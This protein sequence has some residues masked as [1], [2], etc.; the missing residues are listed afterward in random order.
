MVRNLQRLL[1]VIVI[2]FASSLKGQSVKNVHLGFPE[3]WDGDK[4]KELYCPAKNI[5][6]FIDGYFLC[7]L[8]ASYGN[9]NAPPGQKLTHMIDAIGA[10]GS[11]HISNGQVKFSA[12]YYPSKPY[13]IWEYYDRN[14]SKGSV[15]WAGW[16][17]Y[18]L[19]AMTKW[20]QVPPN[21]DATKFHPNLDFWKIGNKVVAGT[22]APYWVGY[23]FDVATLSDFKQ[24]P[25][26]E[27]NDIFNSSKSKMVPISMA[28]HERVDGTGTIWGSF[29][30]M[31][32]HD[33]IFYQAI[34]TIDSEGRRKVISM[35]DYGVW[36]LNECGK[37]DEYVGDKANLPGYVHSITSTEN[38]IILPISSLLINPCKFKEPPIENNRNGIQK[39]GLWG[40]DFY[41]MVPV[42]FLIFNKKTFKWTTEKP[43]EVF[44]SMFISHQLNAYEAE[45]GILVADM[46][47]YDSHEPYIKY[48]YSS[49]LTNNLY[50][51]TA[52]LLRFT[53][54]IKNYKVKY[55]Y[56]LP[57]ETISGDFPQINHEYES[58]KYQWTYLVEYPFASDNSIIKI[59]VQEPSGRNNLKFSGESSMVLHEPYFIPTPGATTEDD[60]VLLVRGLEL[61]TNKASLL[62]INATS[63]T[64]IGRA[65]VGISIPFGFHNRFFS[66]LDLGMKPSSYYNQH[67]SKI[68]R[69]PQQQNVSSRK[70]VENTSIQTSSIDTI[71]ENT[72]IQNSSV[73]TL[74]T[75]EQPEQVT[76]NSTIMSTTTTTPKSI[77]TTKHTSTT[78]KPTTTTKLIEETSKSSPSSTMMTTIT[79]TNP[80]QTTEPPIIETK[81]AGASSIYELRERFAKYRKMRPY[82][83]FGIKST[84]TPVDYTDMMS[85]STPK[86]PK[87]ETPV[88]Q[89]PIYLTS[90]IP[91]T[92]YIKQ[93]TTDFAPIQTITPPPYIYTT[94]P[95]SSSTFPTK[96]TTTRQ[97]P[98]TTATPPST[99]TVD[100]EKTSSSGKPTTEDKVSIQF[101]EDTLKTLCSW[102]PKVFK[103]I[104]TER[105]LESGHSALKWMAPIKIDQTTPT[106]INLKNTNQVESSPLANEIVKRIRAAHLARLQ[107]ENQSLR[108]FRD[109]KHNNLKAVVKKETL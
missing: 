52:R 2:I 87:M 106:M 12:K 59:N 36:D 42:R 49:F 81:K 62:V 103:S 98:V 108:F 29:S 35:Y 69:K 27:D 99:T 65:H 34:F 82:S 18:N 9:Q 56:L 13:K 77:S 93:T 94:V 37:D 96:S 14:M 24:H 102:I 28:I 33:Q 16:S 71:I 11:F 48:F 40:M 76:E 31:N 90:S 68:Y 19:T 15:P 41:N 54:D 53:L 79:T 32:F 97:R 105:C 89:I 101:Y 39:G 1:P 61:N 100:E 58:Q 107:A 21:P 7:Q 17:D 73:D 85:S 92:T 91:P 95:K 78:S 50:P 25:F 55:N 38:Y 45:D 86:Y 26:I 83:A 74:I 80:I 20:D 43:L 109:Q 75:T 30:V 10:V 67:S 6:K 64:E 47:V 51:S 84:Q 5:P 63:M 72:S 23:E 66:K 44:P 70:M 104:T 46:I 60:G 88:T 4:Y 8:S 3:R 22:E 57:Q